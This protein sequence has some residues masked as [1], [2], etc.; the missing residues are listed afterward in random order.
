MQTMK[1][2]I[3]VAGPDEERLF[4]ALLATNLFGRGVPQ[5]IVVD[6]VPQK[7]V[8]P[9]WLERV[10]PRAKSVFADFD[11]ERMLSLKRGII[12]IGE[13]PDAPRSA[14]WMLSVLASLDFTISAMRSLFEEWR[15][16][17]FDYDAPS[18]GNLQEKL[19]WGCAFRG[20]GQKR[21][22]SRRWL[23]FGPWRLLRGPGDTSLVQ[24]HDL[25]ADA[26]TALA[27]ARPGHDRMGF[28]NHGGFIPREYVP[29][30]PIDGLYEP[31]ERKLKVLVHGRDV[32]QGEM[33]D[34]CSARFHQALGPARPIEKVA[35][36][37]AEEERARAHVH[38]LWLRDLECWTFV[39][40]REKRIDTEHHPTPVK[41]DWV[42][43]LENQEKN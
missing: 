43:A 14:E 34:A 33:L 21:L 27:Q 39:A 4:R 31:A 8:D 29:E 18:F 41:P 5:R 11:P 9:K 42:L 32:S 1:L 3:S 24:F 15:D 2:G 17:P 19:G 28:S 36:V 25:E 20:E 6:W 23:D 35:Y 22:V 7:P 26:A 40:G 16:P 37:F 12:V 10:L 30:N 13:T 38:E